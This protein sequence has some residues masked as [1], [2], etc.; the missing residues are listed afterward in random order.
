M[1]SGKAISA[2]HSCLHDSRLL[3]ERLNN[4]QTDAF[5][6]QNLTTGAL[7]GHAADMLKSTRP[8]DDPRILG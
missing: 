2:A 1:R 8:G 5:S 3:F 4:L 6:R 7:T